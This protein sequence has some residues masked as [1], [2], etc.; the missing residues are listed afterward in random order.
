[1]AIESTLPT[2]EEIKSSPQSFTEKEMKDI[3][4]LRMNLNTNTVRFGQLNIRKYKLEEAEEDLKNDL[5]SLE[6]L[7]EELAKSLSDKYGKGSIDLETG[8][9]T[10]S[11]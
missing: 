6:K 4:D 10:P 2:P 11:E 9:F 3:K 7:E 8:T 1:M 5:K